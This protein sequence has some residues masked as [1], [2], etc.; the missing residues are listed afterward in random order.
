MCTYIRAFI[1]YI[2]KGNLRTTAFTKYS[3]FPAFT[4]KVK[5]L[6]FKSKL[7]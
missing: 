2:F 5:S 7:K 6:P 3:V 1:Y 4:V